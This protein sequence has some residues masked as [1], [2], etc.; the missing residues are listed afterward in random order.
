MPIPSNIPGGIPQRPQQPIGVPSRQ[1]QQVNK[2]T[3]VP[4]NPQQEDESLPSLPSNGEDFTAQR[5][6][7]SEYSFNDSRFSN[8]R[9][10]RE[11]VVNP[12]D[13]DDDDTFTPISVDEQFDAEIDEEEEIRREVEARRNERRNAAR[14][15]QSNQRSQ[16]EPE[17]GDDD[18]TDSGNVEEDFEKV[19]AKTGRRGKKRREN[20]KD[21]KGQDLF[22]D[23]KNLKLKPFGGRSR[24]I[25]EGEFD[26]RKNLRK[27]A[28][29]VQWVV[30]G[31][32]LVLIGLG[33][34]NAVFPAESLS[35]EEVVQIAEESSGATDFPVVRGEAYAT[36]FMKAFLT[37]ED[38]TASQ[39]LGYFYN[40]NLAPGNNANRNVSSG[41]KQRVIF[42]PT[43]YSAQAVT[44]HSANYVLGSL[45]QASPADGSEAVE[46]TEPRWMFFNVNVYYDEDTDRMYITPE[47]PTIVP[48]SEVGSIEE[49]P[50]SAP[51]GTGVSDEALTAE[52]QS[53]VHGF[54]KG[55][56]ESTSENYSTLEQ[57]IINDAP[58]SL[59]NG[60]G[61]VYEFSGGLENSVKYT[62]YP[63]DDENEIKVLVTVMWNNSLGS[64]DSTFTADYNS[65][66]VMTLEKQS[67]KWLVSRFQPL[68]YVK[69]NVDE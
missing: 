10:V 8:S 55:Y 1:P 28:A 69:D 57:Y 42:G 23:E 60:L 17:Y 21:S 56:S 2:V 65:T 46:G 34:K 64:V 37:T 22:V 5:S 31:L 41:F 9:A 68:L 48:T 52:I 6:H 54:M 7:T 40:G 14:K 36:D 38:D 3:R 4:S 67:S 35:V 59:K 62:A 27:N 15:A 11:P 44:D 39:V 63:T 43:T 32:V 66:Y 47:S 18:D 12:Y 19:S 53:V 29:I 13:P 24:K 33:V 26:N 20:K 51:L 61:G 50:P 45:V 49:V 30:V 58:N 16:P 25:K